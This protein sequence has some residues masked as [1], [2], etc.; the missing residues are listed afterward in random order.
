MFNVR[1]FGASGVAVPGP[2]L[3]LEHRQFKWL[4]YPEGTHAVVYD[5]A[6]GRPYDSVGLQA[7]I[8]AAH[9]AGGGVVHVPAG[10][11]L[12]GPIE[13]KSRVR[14]HLDG[15]ARLWGSPKIADYLPAAGT[16]FPPYSHDGDPGRIRDRMNGKLRLISAHGAEDISITGRGQISGQSPAF[17]IPWMNTRP[18]HSGGLQRPSDMFLFHNCRRIQLEE[19]RVLDAPCWGIVFDLCR[20]VQVRG[21]QIEGLDV[22]NSDGIDLVNT[23]DVG[24]SDCRFHVTDDAICLKNC[25]ADATMRNIVVTNCVIRTLCNGVKI[26]TETTGNFENLAVSN[27][28]IQNPDGDVRGGKGVCLSAVDGGRVR[29]VSIT[30]LVMRNV[31]C[32]FYIVNGRR[33]ERQSLHRLPQS[34][35]LEDISLCNV[36]AEGCKYPSFVVGHDGHPVRGVMLSHLRLHKTNGFVLQPH[37]GFVPERLDAYPSPVMFGSV[38]TGDELPAWGLYLRHVENVSVCNLE[39]SSSEPDAR[40][41]LVLDNTRNVQILGGPT[42]KD[43][44]SEPASEETNGLHTRTR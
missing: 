9:A 18:A 29:N 23:S 26:G 1:D 31:G 32:A 24:I 41:P 21:L 38:E 37:S 10:D 5:A 19:I 4:V 27:I 3:T 22:I 11:Y 40:E 35:R 15:G 36:Q 44:V 42:Q 34:G 20:H 25:T 13:L 43:V 8:D 7:A 17:V 2:N 6:P 39:L 30:N 16:A 33:V 12:I 14:L 28:T